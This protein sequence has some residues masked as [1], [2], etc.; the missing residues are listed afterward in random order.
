MDRGALDFG[1]AQGRIETLKEFIWHVIYQRNHNTYAL[2]VQQD[3]S[4]VRCEQMWLTV[5][6]FTPKS[7]AISV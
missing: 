4:Q 6:R 2:I 7:L 5:V 1:G 3:F